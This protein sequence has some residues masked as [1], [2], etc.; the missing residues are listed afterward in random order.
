M[1]LDQRKIYAAK[2]VSFVAVMPEDVFALAEPTLDDNGAGRLPFCNI[3][4]LF[5]FFSFRLVLTNVFL[6]GETHGL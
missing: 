3:W 4:C 2:G 5:H 6:G 1:S